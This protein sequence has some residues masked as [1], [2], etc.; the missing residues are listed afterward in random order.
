VIVE[1]AMQRTRLRWKPDI[2]HCNDW[3]TGLVPALLSLEEQAPPSLFTIHNLAYQGLFPYSA[4]IALGLPEQLWSHEALEFHDQLSFIKGGLVYADWI[5]TVSPSYAKEIQTPEFGYGLEGLLSHRTDKLSGILNGI[6][7]ESWD[8]E[9]DPH[10]EASYS[11]REVDRKQLNK[12]ALQEHF[13]LPESDSVL[14]GFIGRL[15]HQK[16][17]DIVLHAMHALMQLPIQMIFLGTGEYE[18]EQSLLYYADE[19]PDRIAANIDYDEDIA[20]QIEAGS[21][22]FL[23]PSRFE[24]C[25]LNQ[26]YSLRYGTLPVVRQVGG[27]ADTVVDANTE[28]LASG[29]ANGF[30]ISDESGRDLLE[31]LTYALSLYQDKLAW[32]KLQIRAMWRDSSWDNSASEYKNLYDQLN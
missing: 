20:H 10:I 7:T 25:G 29:T 19:Y 32:K 16:G 21:D 13:G 22:L 31:T 30:I 12:K 14:V 26:M 24:P 23:M 8:P 18:Y 1:I 27:L 9:N 17:I 5:T 28:T 6:D 2:I 4:F 11:I 3:Q 15:V